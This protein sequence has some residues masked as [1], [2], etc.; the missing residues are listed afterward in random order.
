MDNLW[1]TELIAHELLILSLF[2]QKYTLCQDKSYILINF[3]FAEA[4]EEVA[5]RV[6]EEAYFNDEY[7][8]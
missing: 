8:I 3:S 1:K 2:W 4:L 6:A 5:T 7:L